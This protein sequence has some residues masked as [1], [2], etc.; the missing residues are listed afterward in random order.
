MAGKKGDQL[1]ALSFASIDGANDLFTLF[2]AS[3]TG[4][5]PDDYDK[6][7]A[8]VEILKRLLS[9]NDISHLPTAISAF[10]TIAAGDGFLF[11][12]QSATGVKLLNADVITTRSLGSAD[13][14]WMATL[15]LTAA[16]AGDFLVI[17]DASASG[18]RA[19]PIADLL[20]RLTPVTTTD[21]S[22]TPYLVPA[23]WSGR[24]ITNRGA[25]A[26][27]ELDMPPFTVGMRFEITRI[28]DFAFRVDPNGSETIAG[29]GAG[30][31]LEVTS[32]GSVILECLQAGSLEVVGGSATWVM[33]G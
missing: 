2:D 25:A 29:G 11:W 10:A 5:P 9:T 17:W 18:F 14:S 31:Y 6:K 27:Q 22:S 20:S 15:G 26:I 1:P 30:K 21:I 33:E 28:S 32:R 7:L 12:D 3:A 13:L 19:V 8:A 23:D 4:T 24:R 16:V